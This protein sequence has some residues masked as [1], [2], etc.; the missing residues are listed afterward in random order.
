M[1]YPVIEEQRA[2]ARAMQQKLWD[3]RSMVVIIWCPELAPDC[4][5]LFK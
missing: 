4:S 2:L 3:I 1:N 5:Y